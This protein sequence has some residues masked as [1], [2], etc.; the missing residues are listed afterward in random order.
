MLLAR[1]DGNATSTI[2]H[3]TLAGWRQLIC[4]PL[5]ENGE[6]QGAP[7]LAADP[8][9]AGQYDKVIITSD[10]KHVREVVKDNHSP[11]RYLIIGIVDPD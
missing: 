3:R 4:Q 2:R 6:D 5:D 11:M 9:G 7:I 10:G 8:L 1:V